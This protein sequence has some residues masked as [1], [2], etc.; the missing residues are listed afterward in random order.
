VIFD[1]R[2]I[3]HFIWIGVSVSQSAYLFLLLF[4]APARKFYF[5]ATAFDFSRLLSELR[6]CVWIV[7]Q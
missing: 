7:E 4:N 1:L 2:A 3:G 5:W 6:L